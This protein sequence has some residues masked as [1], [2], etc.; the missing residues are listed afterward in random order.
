MGAVFLLYWG[1]DLEYDDD[2]P[3]HGCSRRPRKVLR[4]RTK[5]GQ[6]PTTEVVGFL[7][8]RNRDM[9]IDTKFDLGDTVFHATHERYDR[10]ETCPT[11]GHRVPA[12]LGTLQAV[13]AIVEQIR[14]QVWEGGIDIW[15]DLGTE[16][17]R[18]EVLHA[19]PEEAL[20]S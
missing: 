9:R 3:P 20:S 17:F 6:P 13:G 15:Y 18:E 5:D 12:P 16:P 19:T 11:C 7:A 4:D 14:I 8:K 2:Q 1:P 10:E